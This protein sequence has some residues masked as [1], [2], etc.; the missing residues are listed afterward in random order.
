M[1]TGVGRRETDDGDIP[2]CCGI[3]PLT[4]WIV[5]GVLR[6]ETELDEACPL[7]PGVM[8]TETLLTVALDVA[9][10]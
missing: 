8:R 6:M 4:R 3:E 1:L 9:W 2:S 10:L 7:L 5:D